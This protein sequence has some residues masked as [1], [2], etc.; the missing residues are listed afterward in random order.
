MPVKKRRVPQSEGKFRDWI[1]NFNNNFPSVAE[2]IDETASAAM[3]AQ[4]AAAYPYLIMRN[5]AIRAYQK[6]ESKIKDRIFNGSIK[7]APPVLPVLNLPKAPPDLVINPGIEEYMSLLVQRI[8]KHPNCTPEIEALLGIELKD[9]SENLSPDEMK[10]VIKE[11][12]ALNGAIKIR[13]SL[14]GMKAFRVLCQR[15][16]DDKFEPVGDSS[17]TAFEDARPNLVEGQPETR[18]YR[19]VF[20]EN[21]KPVGEFSAVETIV[22]KP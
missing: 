5:D 9:E 12:A 1:G 11:I 19:L 6:E 18:N 13:A 20:L 7:D 15:G 22:T 16:T 17:Q 8:V 14:Q 3:V 4:N 10:P 2:T 21:N